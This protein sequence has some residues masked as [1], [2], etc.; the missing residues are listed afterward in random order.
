MDRRSLLNLVSVVGCGPVRLQ[1]GVV[2][3]D[4][5]GAEL[6]AVDGVVPA[7]GRVGVPRDVVVGVFFVQDLDSAA[8]LVGVVDVR[9]V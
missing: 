8:V 1:P 6:V 9:S 2:E 3:A 7:V 5:A 4:P